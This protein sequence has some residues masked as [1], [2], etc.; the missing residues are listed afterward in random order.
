MTEK[1][2]NRTE[3]IR[4]RLSPD[5]M[6]RY[7]HQAARVGMTPS[8]LAAFVIGQWVK[9]QEDQLRIQSVAVMDAARKIA[10][11]FDPVQIESL[12]AE[13]L[14]AMAPGML[15]NIQQALKADK[16]GGGAD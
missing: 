7:E 6:A 11:Q 14:D 16:G 3:S 12:T 9:T 2:A 13:M 5:L 15:R 10:P 1:P 4:I 8:T